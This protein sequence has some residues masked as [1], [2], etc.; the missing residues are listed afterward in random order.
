[1]AIPVLSA[2]GHSTE[3]LIF[4]AW[5]DRETATRAR[6]RFYEGLSQ[7]EEAIVRVF[8]CFRYVQDSRRL[9]GGTWDPAWLKRLCREV[10]TG[11]LP[12]A[13]AVSCTSAATA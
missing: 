13:A 9:R 12:Q 7:H 11:L 6:L 2:S 8:A 5:K 1:M 4:G 10:E 3:T